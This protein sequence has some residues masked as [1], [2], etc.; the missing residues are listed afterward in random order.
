MRSAATRSPVAFGFVMAAVIASLFGAARAGRFPHVGAPAAATPT[1]APT[2]TA[3]WTDAF[4]RNVAVGWGSPQSGMN[5]TLDPQTSVFTANGTSGNVSI[6]PGTT[7]TSTLKGLKTTDANFTMTVKLNKLPAAGSLSVAV[8]PRTIGTSDYR[9]VFQVGA[10]GAT[11]WRIQEV[12]G[13]NA[14]A[15]TAS[16]P[17]GITMDAGTQVQLRVT[18]TGTA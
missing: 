17:A 14:I 4:G 18:A 5:Y 11:A 7:R 9:A 8:S 13:T 16:I 12:V 10:A 1:P 3:L 15:L 2:L 6:A